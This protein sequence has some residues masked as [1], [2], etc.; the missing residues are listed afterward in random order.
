V[1]SLTDNNNNNNNNKKKKSNTTRVLFISWN[2]ITYFGLYFLRP[3]SGRKVFFQGKLCNAYSVVSVSLNRHDYKRD[4]N[5]WIYTENRP[6]YHGR[7]EI[8]HVLMRKLRT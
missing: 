1:Y 5:I 2:T 8:L 7:T 4:A 3:S 6:K